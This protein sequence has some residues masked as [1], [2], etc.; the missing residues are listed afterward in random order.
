[1]VS[2]TCVFFAVNVFWATMSGRVATVSTVRVSQKGSERR[3][4]V[5]VPTDI[6]LVYTAK[7]CLMSQCRVLK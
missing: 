3:S 4:C 6:D 2:E 5:V 7:S 1:M